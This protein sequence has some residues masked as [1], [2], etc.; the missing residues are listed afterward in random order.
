M[1]PGERQ[2]QQSDQLLQPNPIGEVAI[3]VRGRAGIAEASGAL[4]STFERAYGFSLFPQFALSD[5]EFVD[6]AFGV[7][8]WT[9]CH[10]AVDHP[11]WPNRRE[12]DDLGL[13]DGSEV[14]TLVKS[15]SIDRQTLS[16]QKSVP[17]STEEPS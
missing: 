1:R 7:S 13:Q 8:E 5:P 4:D 3:F 17:T 6:G 16:T 9:D 10:T 14:Y 12:N 11:E 2:R 15:T